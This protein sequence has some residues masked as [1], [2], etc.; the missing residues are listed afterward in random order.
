[1]KQCNTYSITQMADDGAM[2]DLFHCIR[3]QMMGRCKTYSIA[4]MTDDGAMQNLFQ[5]SFCSSWGIA[6]PFPMHH[7]ADDGAMQTYSIAQVA[8]NGAMQNLFHC[9]RWQMMGQCKTLS[10]TVF[11]ST[12]SIAN[13]IPTCLMEYCKPFNFV[14][15]SSQTS[16]H[17]IAVHLR[18]AQGAL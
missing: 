10:S 14:E 13:P 9:I 11:G 6:K 8:N 18:T 16:L 12:W 3:W 17:S 2:Q 7:M 1:M 5:Y 4:Q 15:Y